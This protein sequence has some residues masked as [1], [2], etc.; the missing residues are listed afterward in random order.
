[1]DGIVKYKREEKFKKKR[2]YIFGNKVGNY[3]QNRIGGSGKGYPKFSGANY[4]FYDSGGLF[5][6]MY[7]VYKGKYHY[8][9]VSNVS[10]LKDI[11]ETVNNKNLIGLTQENVINVDKEIIKPNLDKWILSIL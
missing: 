8:E 1:M 2:I 10:Y 9:I 5:K 6:S 7:V 11:F 4:N 3:R